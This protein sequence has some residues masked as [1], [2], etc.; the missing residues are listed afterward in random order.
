MMIEAEMLCDRVGII[1]H[2]KIVALD[3]PSNLKK[4]ISGDDT[5]VIELNISNLTNEMFH[6]LEKLECVNRLSMI[7]N[8]NVKVQANGDDAFDI[9][10]DFV[11][12]Q[13][14]KI[15]SVKNLEPTLEDVF[16][17][18]TGREVRDEANEKPRMQIRGPG[19]RGKR[20]V[21]SRVR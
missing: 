17:H 10:L 6:S 12:Q 9:I 1:D 13:K 2:G 14:G 11:R 7:G 18:I 4:M 5:I 21:I 19:R 15:T 8:T 16:L 3:T 20:K